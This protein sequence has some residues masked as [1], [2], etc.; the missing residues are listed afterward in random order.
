[1]MAGLQACTSKQYKPGGD[2]AS[3]FIHCP[4]DLDGFGVRIARE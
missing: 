2:E 3:G 1:M 4:D